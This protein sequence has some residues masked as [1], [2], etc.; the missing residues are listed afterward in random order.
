MVRRTT[1]VS[2]LLAGVLL[3]ASCTESAG[4]ANERARPDAPSFSFRLNGITLNKFIELYGQSGTVDGHPVLIKGFNPISPDTG[5]AVIA[6]F[7]WA[8]PPDIIDSVIDV[9]TTSPYTPVGNTYTL[10]KQVSAG[11]F[12]M[13]TYVAT[14]IRNFPSGQPEPVVY[15]VAAYLKQSVSS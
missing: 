13:A 6:T 4:P 9:M 3:V 1:R 5:D 8:G 15:A 7:A 2:G 12:N 14:G 10:V 11:G